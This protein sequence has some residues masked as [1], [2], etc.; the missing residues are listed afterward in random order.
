MVQLRVLFE[1]FRE[2]VRDIKL[3]FFVGWPC[4]IAVNRRCYCHPQ[5]AHREASGSN[6][7]GRVSD[8]SEMD[9]LYLD[10]TGRLEGFFVSMKHVMDHRA[11]ELSFSFL[12]VFITKKT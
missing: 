4:N 10:R 6:K 12:T 3:L 11:R 9:V 1:P 7:S 5:V 8:H 2:Y